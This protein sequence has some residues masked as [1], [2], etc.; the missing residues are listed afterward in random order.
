MLLK[1]STNHTA[2]KLRI[3]LVC[4]DSIAESS[5]T[6][7]A[8]PTYYLNNNIEVLEPLR[9]YIADCK[10]KSEETGFFLNTEIHQLL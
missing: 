9:Q 7:P 8:L 4:N 5:S 1:T 3:K 2:K 6:K 10:Q